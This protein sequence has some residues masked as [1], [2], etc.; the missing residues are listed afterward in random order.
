[1]FDLK[2]HLLL[3]EIMKLVNDIN[4]YSKYKNKI[5]NMDEYIEIF[6]SFMYKYNIDETI[7]M[8][9]R[10]YIILIQ[11]YFKDYEERYIDKK[12]EYAKRNIWKSSGNEVKIRC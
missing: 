9:M 8:K 7:Y 3:K 6:D 11:A 12:L 1:M 5:K 4:D 10:G 2:Y